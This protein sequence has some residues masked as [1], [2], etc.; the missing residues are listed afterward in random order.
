[1]RAYSLSFLFMLLVSLDPL[2]AKAGVTSVHHTMIVNLDPQ[3]RVLEVSD[4]LK[5]E[6]SGEAIFHLA[7]NL[8]IT[9][10]KKNGKAVSYIR[11]KKIL[12]VEL[13]NKNQHNITLKYRGLLPRLPAGWEDLS[14]MH[15]VAS[16]KGSYLSSWSAWHPYVEDIP[17][18]YRLSVIVP[19]AH[20]AIVP[21][22]LVEER[23]MDG[24]YNAIFE[25]EIPTLGIVL[26]AGPLVIKERRHNNL[27]LRTYFSPELDHLS[28]EYLE[29]TAEYIDYFKDLIGD[30]PFSSF[31]IVSGPFPVGLG[32]SGMTYMGERVLQLPFIR[33]TS[34]GHEILH[35]WWGNGIKIDYKSGNWAEGLTTYMADYA[36]SEKRHSDNAKRM[37]TEWL[38]NY[39][40]LP[41]RRDQSVR[42]FISR[43]HDASQIIGYNKVA[44]IFHMLSEKVGKEIFKHSI[45]RFWDQ[46]KFQTA[47]WEDIQKTFEE[48]SSMDLQAFFEQ[49]VDRSGAPRLMMSNINLKAEMI[50]FNLSQLDQPYALDVPIKLTTKDGTELF[51]ASI[52]GRV[53]QVNLQLSGRPISIS[54]DPN[55][56]IF[57][58]LDTIETSPILRDTTLSDESIVVLISSDEAM[59]KTAKKLVTSMMDA[60]PHFVKASQISEH[61]GPTLII[62]TTLEVGKFLQKNGLPTTPKVLKGRGSARVWAARRL[63][64]KGTHLPLLV[65]EANDPEAIQNLLRPLPHY[66]RRS[67]LVFNASKVLDVG[68]WPAEGN[69]LT[70]TFN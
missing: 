36:F 37:R 69:P 40:S 14:R 17:A 47:S 62:G 54:V 51:R 15:L 34:L 27:L 31:S 66:G 41:Q 59:Q 63:S 35:N 8:T 56:D 46:H 53:S 5:V 26:I 65:V 19:E 4:N 60:S 23:S 29:S 48:I 28:E 70:V 10:I 43:E 33:Y 3:Q 52:D 68:V 39:A 6:G 30:Y 57:R 7:P 49:W 32:F 16:K 13:G 38:Q 2:C 67:Y 24:F 11:Q 21:G 18:S 12:R 20:K 1:M 55:F 9:S 22:R 44:F 64:N 45:Q 25:S 50:S 58:R 42:S 61:N